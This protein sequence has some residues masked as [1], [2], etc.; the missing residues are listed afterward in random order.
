LHF[1]SSAH[2]HG[3]SSFIAHTIYKP[4]LSR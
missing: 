1:Q 2:W 4:H 3:L